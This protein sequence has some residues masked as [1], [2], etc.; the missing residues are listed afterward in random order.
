MIRQRAADP[1]LRHC[2]GTALKICKC[3]FTSKTARFTQGSNRPSG[4]YA[5]LCSADCPR[6][7][8]PAYRNPRE[9]RR[10]HPAMFVYEQVQP[11]EGSD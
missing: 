7:G 1:L 3:D 6:P 5:I 9:R 8:L 11:W 10:K 2:A 4:F